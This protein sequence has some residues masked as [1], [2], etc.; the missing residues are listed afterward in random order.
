[1]TDAVER[2]AHRWSGVPHEQVDCEVSAPNRRHMHLLCRVGRDVQCAVPLE[3]V[4]ETMRPL[5]ISPM[6]GVPSF[7]QGLALVRGIPTP[8]VNVAALLSGEPSCPTRFVTL[9]TGTRHLALAVDVVVGIIDIPPGSVDALPTLLQGA[10]LDAISA[11]GVL[12]A[13]LL[14][15]LRSTHLVSVDVWAAFQAGCAAACST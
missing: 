9:R 10:E 6:A 2:D 4:T 13:E 11:I 8:V 7:I 1:V 3:H 15:V 5:A 14:L 12:D